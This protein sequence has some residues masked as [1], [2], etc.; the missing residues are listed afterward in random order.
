MSTV[1]QNLSDN[2][3]ETVQTA[4]AAVVR[5]DARRRLPATGIIWSADGLIL[6]A[7]HVVR[8]QDNITVGLPDGKTVGASLVGHDSSTD[9]AMLKAD[10]SGL[11]PAT[12]QSDLA[13]GHLVLALGR[14]GKTVQA[15]LGVVSALGEAWRTPAGGHIDQYLQTDVLM[16]PGFSGGPLVGAG[17]QFLG[18]NSSALLRGVSMAVPASTLGR[19]ADSLLAHGRI[20]R[21]YLGIST[22][23]VRLPQA[24]RDELGQETGLLVVG[25]EPDSPADRSGLVLGDTMTQ[26]DGQAIRSHDDL[27]AQLSGDRVNQKVPVGI[28]RG[29]E[30][31]TINV[32]V[33]ERE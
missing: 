22:Q 21:G 24:V 10:A 5:V 15:T 1:L 2:L 23:P 11:T 26:F 17:G 25:V 9:L 19:V 30:I 18:L 28:L 31:R 29:G 14:P 20:K 6:T 3:A 16:Y 32:T 8:A 13:V 27:L 4:G 7:R 33:G 12:W